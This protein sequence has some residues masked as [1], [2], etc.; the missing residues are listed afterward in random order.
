MQVKLLV[1]R[2]L[3]TNFKYQGQSTSKWYEDMDRHK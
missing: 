2:N 1:N 3:V